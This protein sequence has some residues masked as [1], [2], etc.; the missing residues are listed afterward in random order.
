[1][2]RNATGASDRKLQEVW[3]AIVG[4]SFNAHSTKQPVGISS[5]LRKVIAMSVTEKMFPFTMSR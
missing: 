4:C 3:R 1:M 5:A 2:G